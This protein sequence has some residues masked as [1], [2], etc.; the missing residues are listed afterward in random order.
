MKKEIIKLFII[1][2]LV[3]FGVV[4]VVSLFFPWTPTRSLYS[5][6]ILDKEGVIESIDFECG[7]FLYASFIITVSD[8]RYNC[9]NNEFYTLT[10]SELKR[11]EIRSILEKMGWLFVE[12]GS[13]S[14]DR[15]S[16]KDLRIRIIDGRMYYEN[17]DKKAKLFM[18]YSHKI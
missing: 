7:D 13:P 18:E 6:F 12:S 1:G 2:F 11:K 14:I 17:L 16:K 5:K 4:F 15:Y 9:V 8:P 3:L 10:E